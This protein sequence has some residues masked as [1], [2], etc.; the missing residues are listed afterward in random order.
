MN[1][2][3]GGVVGI[4]TSPRERS[5]DRIRLDRR[6]ERLLAAVV[7]AHVASSTP[8]ASRALTRLPG[9][10]LSAASIRAT[11]A[12]LERAA[13][14]YRPHASSGRIPTDQ[15]YRYYVDRLLGPLPVRAD[16]DAL[17]ARVRDGR[18]SEVVR[19]FAREFRCF[20]IAVSDAP[21]TGDGVVDV[22][23]SGAA[24]LLRAAE[25]ADPAL[26]APLFE[27]VDR[28]ET[29]HRTLHRM[30]GRTRGVRVRIGREHDIDALA[31]CTSIVFTLSGRTP[32][33]TV[34]LVGPTR[35]DYRSL[36]PRV[37]QLIE[38]IER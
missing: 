26:A 20:A 7:E 32:A 16:V 30:H 15:G 3:S 38:R 14:L 34:A 29:L 27:L 37:V 10:R 9:E 35:L 12:R 31:S 2:M 36:I 13:C 25:F 19:E 5:D 24:H 22:W 28:P 17:A 1:A 23:I 6:Q 4:P 11:L 8:V 21:A 33:A 18:G